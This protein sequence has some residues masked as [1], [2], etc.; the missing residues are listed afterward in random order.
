MGRRRFVL[1]RPVAEQELDD[2]PLV[3]LQP[4]ELDRLVLD[5]LAGIP[6]L[7]VSRA[8]RLVSRRADELLINSVGCKVGTVWPGDG[9]V[10]VDEH[11]GKCFWIAQR[12]EDGAEQPVMK[13]DFAFRTIVEPDG[14]AIVLEWMDAED[15]GHRVLFQRSDGVQWLVDFGKPPILA[16]LVAMF[17]RPF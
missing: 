4:V 16:Q 6:L 5:W 14:E 11:L 12:L 9:P 8:G 10:L 17:H 2:V 3:R 13:R 1:K 15:S 7:A